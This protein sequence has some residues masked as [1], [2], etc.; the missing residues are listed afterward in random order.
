M[1]AKAKSKE[2]EDKKPERK[3]K[4]RGPKG[5]DPQKTKIRVLAKENPKREGSKAHARFEVYENGMTVE[6]ALAAGVTTADLH[7]DV[8]KEF[9]KLV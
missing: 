6:D 4:K 5:V 7:N 1:A 2:K 3:T 8:S 9:I